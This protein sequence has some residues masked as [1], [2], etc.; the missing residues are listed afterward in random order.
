MHPAL[1]I[2]RRPVT[3]CLVAIAATAGATWVLD[4]WFNGDYWD[5][6]AWVAWL[7]FLGAL[8]GVAASGYAMVESCRTSKWWVI[9]VAVPVTAGLLLFGLVQLYL[10]LI[11]VQGVS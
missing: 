4:R 2:L 9:L 8:A 1:L 3:S 7:G 6:P 11:V 5:G 10:Y